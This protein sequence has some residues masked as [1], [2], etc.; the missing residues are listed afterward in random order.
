[1]KQNRSAKFQ[2]PNV[3]AQLLNIDDAAERLNISSHTVRGLVRQRKITFVKL[4]AR[5]LF[6]PQD[7]EEFIKSHLVP[8]QAGG[9]EETP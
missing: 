3:N 9:Q 8:A 2:N 7:L 5:V 1:M 6:R 4:G